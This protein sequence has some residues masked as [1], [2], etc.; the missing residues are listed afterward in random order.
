MKTNN[1]NEAER[2]A[3]AVDVMEILVSRCYDNDET[4]EAGG[5]FWNITGIKYSRERHR[6]TLE[7]DNGDLL[8]IF[9]YSHRNQMLTVSAWQDRE[10][11]SD[12]TGPDSDDEGRNDDSVLVLQLVYMPKVK[13]RAK[14]TKSLMIRDEEFSFQYITLGQM[15]LVTFLIGRLEEYAEFKNGEIFTFR[16]TLEFVKKR[17][18]LVDSFEM[19]RE[20]L[21][22]PWKE[23][24]NDWDTLSDD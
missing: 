21:V 17:Q 14:A 18:T 4:L 7:I 12:E 2:W 9:E 8:L 15:A 19:M 11:G 6:L 13:G 1:T 23:I 24:E 20:A 22:E 3:H 5:E 16:K 10:L